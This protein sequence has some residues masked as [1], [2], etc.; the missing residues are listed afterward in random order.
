MV[1]HTLLIHKS[2]EPHSQKFLFTF[3]LFQTRV[4]NVLQFPRPVAV[5][6]VESKL[7]ADVLSH[8]CF[9]ASA[10]HSRVLVGADNTQASCHLLL[11]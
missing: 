7:F 4:L 8:S 1:S 5:G 11:F 2:S 3:S 6:C 10:H 9:I